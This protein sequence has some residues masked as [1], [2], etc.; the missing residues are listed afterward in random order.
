MSTRI[1]LITGGSRSGKTARALE[2]AM[3]FEPRIYLATAQ[4][5]DDEMHERIAR[6]K[7]ERADRFTTLEES[8]HLGKAL[9]DVPD[10]TGVVLIDCLTVW[11]GN[12]MHIHGPQPE[13]YDEVRNFLHALASPP[14]HIMIVTNE[15]G[16]GIVPHE[17]MTRCFR[18]HAGWLNQ[19][20]AR[21]AD[22]V[23]LVAC[24]LPLSLKNTPE[25]VG[26]A[27]PKLD[28]TQYSNKTP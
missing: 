24:G 25:E 4:A 15:V 13:P 7:A 18:D 20:V 12:L 19:D 14:C 23:E 28:H 8:Q 27:F 10:N 3:A 2:L 17:A 26:T 16:S 6:H 21:I 5:F 9:Q 1:T 11:L 22:R